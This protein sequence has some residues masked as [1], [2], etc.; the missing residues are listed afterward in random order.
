[1]RWKTRRHSNNGHVSLQGC[2]EKRQLMNLFLEV[3]SFASPMGANSTPA[4]LQLVNADYP[5]VSNF[6]AV[7]L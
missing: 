1:M 4:L 2:H 6:A 5:F 3:V 7:L